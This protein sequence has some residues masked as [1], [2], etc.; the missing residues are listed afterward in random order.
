MQ[1]VDDG[2][3]TWRIRVGNSN[4]GTAHKVDGGSTGLTFPNSVTYDGR[5]YSIYLKPSSLMDRVV[6]ESCN[7][8]DY[9]NGYKTE[10]VSGNT[11]HIA[12]G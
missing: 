7:E 10:L 1:E 6:D 12:L 3:D 4:I 5:T 11:D 9:V 8:G 2:S